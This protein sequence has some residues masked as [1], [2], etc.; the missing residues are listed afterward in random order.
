MVVEEFPLMLK[1]LAIWLFDLLDVN[2]DLDFGA[3][4]LHSNKRV[5]V[6]R[7]FGAG[8]QSQNRA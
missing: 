8:L 3:S 1:L 4:Y 7:K 2:P 6:A 5:Q